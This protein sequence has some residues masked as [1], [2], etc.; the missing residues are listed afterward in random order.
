MTLDEFRAART[1]TDDVSF[2]AGLDPDQPQ[3]FAGFLYPGNHWVV[4]DITGQGRWLYWTLL[5]CV[6]A[7]SNN[8][9]NLEQLIYTDALAHG[10]L[11]IKAFTYIEIG[12]KPQPMSD[13]FMDENSPLSKAISHELK[14]ARSAPALFQALRA[15]AIKGD[16]TSRH[17]A[18]VA[19]QAIGIAH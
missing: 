2:V 19:L 8:L 18:Q 10:D 16:G 11:D 14:L 12:A 4:H 7:G 17:Y 13:E 3:R 15:I 9:A 1:A 5:D 6:E